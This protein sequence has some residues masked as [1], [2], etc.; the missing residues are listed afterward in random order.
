MLDDPQKDPMGTLIL[1]ARADADVAAL[2]STRVRGFE[3]AEGDAKGPGEYQAFVV[4]SA[5][6]VPLHPQLPI[7]TAEYGIAAYGSTPQN[8]WAV[9]GALAKAFHGIGPRIASSGL[10]IYR[11][12][13]ATGGE[14]DKDPDTGQPLVRGSI[15]L[16]AT[17]QA[18]A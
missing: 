18:I 1:E 9:W 2:V 5:L 13:A 4:I 12:W 3:P 7:T 6:S 15:R 17:A 14:Q 8:A 16:I 11:S 10:G